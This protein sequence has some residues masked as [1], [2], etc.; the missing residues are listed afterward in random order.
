MI[1]LCNFL[2][3]IVLGIGAILPG[4]SS[5]VLCVIMGMY[6]ELINIISNF[7]KDLKKNLLY[8]AP[9]FLGALIG[10]I[11]FS[12]MILFT[13]EKYP[14]QTNSL[15]IGLILRFNSKYYERNKEK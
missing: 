5:G 9:L 2:K 14:L 6:E 7:L 12:K 11:G 10:I 4:I 15:F 8:M 3:G 1:F 13:I